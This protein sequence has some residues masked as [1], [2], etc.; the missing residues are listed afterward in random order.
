MQRVS[1]LSLNEVT[2]IWAK[3]KANQAL[4]DSCARHE[5]QIVPG[6]ELL[7]SRFRCMRCLGEINGTAHR[8]YCT[9]L[10]HGALK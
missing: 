3:V 6:T 2:E 5:F 8:W 4:L 1:H 9:G 7:R 10:A